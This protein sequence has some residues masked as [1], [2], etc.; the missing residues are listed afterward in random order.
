LDIPY[1][2]AL[3]YLGFSCIGRFDEKRGCDWTLGGF[4]QMHTSIIK[5]VEHERPVF[6][7]YEEGEK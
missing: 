6:D 1:E 3:G 2:K 4:F 7:F 5:D